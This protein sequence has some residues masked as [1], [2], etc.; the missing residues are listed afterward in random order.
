VAKFNS[1]ITVMRFANI[2]GLV[3]GG[4]FS[5]YCIKLALFDLFTY[6]V[7]K[8][9]VFDLTP[10]IIVIAMVIG[11]A[12]IALPLFAGKPEQMYLLYSLSIFALACAQ[13][14]GVLS[15]TRRAKF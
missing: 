13:V 14:I 9:S 3:I 8:Y 2:G 12:E 7:R 6:D 1:N 11:I 5:F 10:L 15:V 4:F